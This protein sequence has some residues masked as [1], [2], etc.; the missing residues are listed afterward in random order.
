M[1]N[2]NTS[3]AC[4]V[5]PKD[6]A[7]DSGAVDQGSIAE[8]RIVIYI[9]LVFCCLFLCFIDCSCVFFNNLDFMLTPVVFHGHNVVDVIDRIENFKQD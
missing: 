5:W 2:L 1:V 3:S 8:M 9:F 4:V 6:T 7:H